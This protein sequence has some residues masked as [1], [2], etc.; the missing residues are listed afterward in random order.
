MKSNTTLLRLY[1]CSYPCIELK[2]SMM[3]H[4][5]SHLTNNLC[6]LLCQYLLQTFSVDSSKPTMTAKDPDFQSVMGR[7]TGLD[8]SDIH[9]IH[10]MYGCAD[11]CP[12]TLTCDHVPGAFVGKN[13]ECWCPN[14]DENVPIVE[15]TPSGKGSG[16]GFGLLLL[17]LWLLLLLVFCIKVHRLRGD[18]IHFLSRWLRTGEQNLISQGKIL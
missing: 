14:D 18:L 13:C 8:A 9:L 6:Y 5:R 10:T 15:C 17:L 11:H 4:I 12:S 1:I 16:S 2:T 3:T 7:R